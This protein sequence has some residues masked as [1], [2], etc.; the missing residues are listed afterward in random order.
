MDGFSIVQKTITK[1][2][3]F[4]GI[5]IHSGKEVSATVS[6]A[7]EDSGILF[8]RLDLISNNKIIVKP[9]NIRSFYL[10]SCLAANNEA[11]IITLEHFMAA[12][13]A[14]GITNLTIDMTG[15]EMPI[16]DGSASGYIDLFDK[17]GI[18]SQTKQIAAIVLDREVWVTHN[19]GH[20]VYL[21]ADNF[22]ISYFVDYGDPMIG[23]QQ[24]SYCHSKDAFMREIMNARTFGFFKDVEAMWSRGLALGGSFDNA[25][26]VYEDHYSSEL[27]YP[28][29]P[30]KHKILDLVGDL[31]LLGRP[32]NGHI[33][34]IKSSH[35]LN[36]KFAQCISDAYNLN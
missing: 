27:R 30:V 21:P 18:V 17:V 6:P 14:F 22:E 34:A 28:D 2:F 25:L 24:Y 7:P 12:L 11:R 4:T 13:S 8:T 15:E 16:L 31:Y 23:K 1:A 19:D 9:E 36:G 3:T 29:E 26:V 32:M 5:G 33:I 10:G 35:A 20:L